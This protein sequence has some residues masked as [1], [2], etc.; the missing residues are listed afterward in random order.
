VGVHHTASVHQRLCQAQQRL[1]HTHTHRDP[2]NYQ[3]PGC[4][5]ISE[6]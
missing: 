4:S 6:I 2:T 3:R 1:P 5:I